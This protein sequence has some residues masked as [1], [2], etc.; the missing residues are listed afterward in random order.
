M[1]PVASSGPEILASTNLDGTDVSWFDAHWMFFSWAFALFGLGAL[2]AL[3]PLRDPLWA[4]WLAV[5]M[6]C[7]HQSEE[8]AYDFRGWRYSFVPAL[9]QGFGQVLFGSAC[10]PNVAG[11]PLD[12]QMTT[13]INVTAIWVGFGGCMAL[14]TRYPD[15][16]LFAG[17]L[18]WGTS[19]VNGIG[20][21]LLQV[22]LT[23]SYNPGSVQSTLMVPLGIYIIW[24]TQRPGLCLAYGVLFH[25]IAFGIGMNAVLRLGLPEVPT[26]VFLTLLVA[27]VLPLAISNAIRHPMGA[28]KALAP[29]LAVM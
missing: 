20:G 23:Q 15:R 13:W 14:A 7:F 11:C 21:H 2:A 4:G 1:P 5:V 28:Y 16:F 3:Y 29:T 26:T 22:V 27:L 9:N 18:N 8:H 6:Y 12:P 25:V 24:Q 10:P 17:M 19:V